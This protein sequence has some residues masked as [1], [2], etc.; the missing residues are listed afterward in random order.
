MKTVLAL[1]ANRKFGTSLALANY[2]QKNYKDFIL[3]KNPLDV[4]V[5]N[6]TETNIYANNKLVKKSSSWRLPFSSPLNLFRDILATVS[7]VKKN[8]NNSEND[9]VL[10]VGSNP[11]NTLAGIL[12]KKLNIVNL[13]IYYSVDYSPKR[14]KNPFL[15]RVYHFIDTFCVKHADAIWNVTKRMRDVREKQGREKLNLVTPNGVFLDHI[16]FNKEKPQR[17][18]IRFVYAGTLDKGKGLEFLIDALDKFHDYDFVCDIIGGGDAEDDLKRRAERLIDGEK[19]RFLG[20]M[21]ND[22][23]LDALPN[24]H[25]G[26]A[27]Y[28]NE[29]SHSW[30]GDPVKAKEYLASRLF[31]IITAIPEFS[32]YVDRNGFGIEIKNNEN[33]LESVLQKIFNGNITINYSLSKEDVEK[34]NWNHIYRNALKE[35]LVN[36]PAQIL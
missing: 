20:R 18:P 2:L 12:L 13:V 22:E 33:D 15:N 29:K 17:P 27:L 7:A 32:S 24:Y 4:S 5:R 6:E 1:H 16:H 30:F 8:L 34:I 3:V 31:I 21:N 14:L 9:S 36:F 11:I 19:V 25:I 23:I 10:F 26:M 28:T 35:T